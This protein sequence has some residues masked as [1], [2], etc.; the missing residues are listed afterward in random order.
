MVKQTSHLRPRLSDTMQPASRCQVPYCN[1]L[2]SRSSAV[3]RR[4]SSGV[5]LRCYYTS[6]PRLRSGARIKVLVP[7]DRAARRTQRGRT[8][9]AAHDLVLATTPGHRSQVMSSLSE[10]SVAG[11]LCNGLTDLCSRKDERKLVEP[12]YIDSAF[13]YLR[14]ELAV[15]GRRCLD[16][17][18]R[19]LLSLISD[20]PSC[21]V[22]HQCLGDY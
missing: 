10:K 3:R 16:K 1:N 19:W 4:R 13:A 22:R 7:V 9:P 21:R 11:H 5:V 17:H 20:L 6:L 14:I 2:E 18:T 8:R 12:T 15:L